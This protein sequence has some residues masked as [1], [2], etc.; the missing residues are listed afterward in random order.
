MKW[1]LVWTVIIAGQPGQV[2][3]MDG[4]NAFDTPEACVA[5][6]EIRAPQIIDL[7]KQNRYTADAQLIGECMPLGDEP[8]AAPE[9]G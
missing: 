3:D 5:E 6:A 8:S 2:T 4:V 1:I 7:L 9:E